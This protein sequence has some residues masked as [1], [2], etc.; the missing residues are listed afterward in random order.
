MFL[1][2]PAQLSL[3]C[4]LPLEVDKLLPDTFIFLAIPLKE[5]KVKSYLEVSAQLANCDTITILPHF[6]PY[7]CNTS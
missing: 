3:S 7:S 2:N 1:K 5:V 4:L 6:S